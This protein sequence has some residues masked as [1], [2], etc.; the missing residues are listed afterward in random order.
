MVW[1]YVDTNHRVSHPDYLKV[2][3]I[4]E[5]ADEWF[6][7]NGPEDVV[8]GYEVRVRSRRNYSTS[9]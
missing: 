8:F 7:Q 2:F 3:A 6:K 5:A 9:R 1:I 4:P